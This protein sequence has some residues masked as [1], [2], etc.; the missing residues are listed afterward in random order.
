MGKCSSSPQNYELIDV[1]FFSTNLWQ[2]SEKDC[3]SAGSNL[4][5]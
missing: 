3:G 2:I 1:V 5:L 4:L